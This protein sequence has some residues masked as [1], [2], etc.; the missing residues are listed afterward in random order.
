[1]SALVIVLFILGIVLLIAGADVLVRGASN[2]ALAFGVSPIVVG[3]TVVA[4][5][6][7]APEMAV[8]VK[9][10]LE[11]QAGADIALGN[12][13]GSNI[14]NVLLIL[15]ISAAI[16]PLVVAQQ[17]VR[18]E[19]PIMI[20]VSLV[21]W[22]FASSGGISRLEGLIL[23][24]GAVAY[25][26][27]AVAASRRETAAVKSEIA[28]EVE[29]KTD[30][31]G[32]GRA[33]L[34]LDLLFI[35]A[36]L[37]M[38]VLGSRWLVE[39][40]ITMARL[41]NI[42]EI[43]IGLTVVAIG[44]SLPEV[45]TSVIASL[46]GEREIAVGNVVGS[47]IFNLLCVLG[48]AATISPAGIAVSSSAL[49]FDIPIMTA[50]AVACLPTFFTGF[51]IARGEG[52]LFLAYYGAY[53]IYLILNASHNE[54]VSTFNHIMLWYVLPA[55]ALAILVTLVIDFRQPRIAAARD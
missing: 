35:A 15:G 16:T 12:V 8:S 46:R 30:M 31:P 37:G 25:T 3:L 11:G 40:A 43:V 21:V 53:T 10:A 28:H 51:R 47:N 24:A 41:L 2:L 55:T 38:L 32:K 5:G 20:G 34:W 39:G 27:V 29:E 44:T 33:P 48:L 9:G 7:S 23:F 1:M 6:T 54:A 17:F 36:G 14:C 18:K 22:Y 26:W 50:V 13:V 49:H 45:A 52:L 19:V 4:F 42:S